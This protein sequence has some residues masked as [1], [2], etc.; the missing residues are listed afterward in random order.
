MAA[1]DSLRPVCPGSARYA[2]ARPH[3]A[4]A[5]GRLPDRPD[6]RG[7]RADL[8]LM[9]REVAVRYDNFW[10]LPMPYVGRPPGPH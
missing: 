2:Y 10:R 8:G 4:P 6:G 9:I 3:S 5:A 1:N 7:S